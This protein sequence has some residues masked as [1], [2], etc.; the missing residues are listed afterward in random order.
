[1][2]RLSRLLSAAIL[3]AAAATAVATVA[4]THE[5]ARV[6]RS[7]A[8]A[9]S[10]STRSGRVIVKFKASS[11][12]MAQAVSQA[13]G[14]SGPLAASALGSR[15]GLALRDGRALGARTQVMTAS[16]VSSTTLAEA[17]AQ[18]AD[19]EWAVVDHRRYIQAA[20][21]DDPLYPNGVTTP[22]APA[23][24]Q[25]YLRAPEAAVEDPTG[26]LAVASIN[27]EPAWAITHGSSAIVIADVD[28]GIAPHP[29]L[30]G[31]VDPSSADS[32]VFPATFP[33]TTASTPYG[34]DFVGYAAESGTNNSVLLATANDGSFDDPDPS[35]P[36]D[37]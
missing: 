32:K 23:V 24:G 29:E 35:D 11:R 36:G 16:G 2:A 31:S 18:D 13:N 5:S 15:L 22:S 4:V 7:P 1:M 27:I 25:W 30:T 8:A 14:V 19:V 10:E 21:V 28:T 12:T 6:H 34:Y 3:G 17:L 20:P 33:G 37:W 26:A 9:A